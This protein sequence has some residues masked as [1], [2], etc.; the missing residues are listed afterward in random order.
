MTAG[1]AASNDSGVPTANNSVNFPEQDELSPRI[2]S[3]TGSTNG[4][5]KHLY[6][7][8]AK[9]FH[10][11]ISTTKQQQM[12]SEKLSSPVSSVPGASGEE[13]P[14]KK[15]IRRT[16]T[17]QP[18][19][20]STLPNWDYEDSPFLT[21]YGTRKWGAKPPVWT[22][23]P[24]PSRLGNPGRPMNTSIPQENEHALGSSRN[25]RRTSL[26]SPE[27]KSGGTDIDGSPWQSQ[28]RR[29]CAICSDAKGL[30]R[31][32]LAGLTLRCTH[33][34]NTCIACL[35]KYWKVQMDSRMWKEDLFTCPECLMP[36]EQDTI[37]RYAD[38]ATFE[39]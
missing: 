22:H 36:L 10:A 18:L 31:F 11:D 30:H 23:E 37:R 4:V 20:V 26:P 17:I 38:P 25:S 21:T 2:S 35:Q 33:P 39:R 1:G 6:H 34:T 5:Y 13:Y 24:Q 12:E 3:E 8:A 19:G 32:P 16:N 29:E 15:P 9:S 27:E 28:E 7:K 14:S